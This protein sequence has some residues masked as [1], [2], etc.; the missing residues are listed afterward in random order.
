MGAGPESTTLQIE[1]LCPLG[2]ELFLSENSLGMECPQ[3]SQLCDH[4]ILANNL[5]GLFEDLRGSFLRRLRSLTMTSTQEKLDYLVH[6]QQ[7]KGQDKGQ[8]PLLAAQARCAQ[9]FLQKVQPCR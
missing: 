1:Q 7:G 3:A 6:Q 5:R 8:E 2:R 4:I 9:Y